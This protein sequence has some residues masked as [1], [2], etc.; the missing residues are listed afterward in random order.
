MLIRFAQNLTSQAMM[1]GWCQLKWSSP[2]IQWM[3]TFEPWCTFQSGQLFPAH[4]IILICEKI[5]LICEKM[6]QNAHGNEVLNYLTTSI[7]SK[8]AGMSNY[9][10][11][12]CICAQN[13]MKT[14]DNFSFDLW[15]VQS[16]SNK[17]QNRFLGLLLL[18]HHKGRLSMQWWWWWWRASRWLS[19]LG[20]ELMVLQRRQLGGRCGDKLACGDDPRIMSDKS[21]RQN[22]PIPPWQNTLMETK[23]KYWN[24]AKWDQLPISSCWLAWYGVKSWTALCQI[25][26]S[27][28]TKHVCSESENTLACIKEMP[29][30]L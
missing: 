19:S 27:I 29:Q 1:V 5:I 23:Y 17:I 14:A 24:L 12:H 18:Q 26:T 22:T 13:Y 8:T 20:R 30:S 4:K 2:E 16:T 9:S 28:C 10:I 15:S 6:S 7:S 11:V 3:W 21:I 25:L